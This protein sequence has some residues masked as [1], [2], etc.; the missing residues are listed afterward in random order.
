MLGHGGGV[1]KRLRPV[2]QD[3][4]GRDRFDL[5]TVAVLVDCE[6][7]VMRL[8]RRAAKII[9]GLPAANP[10]PQDEHNYTESLLD[11]C[12]EISGCDRFHCSR[13]GN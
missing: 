3:N 1:R 11:V 6:Q 9:G 8:V 7:G 5:L 10:E 12:R 13:R 4:V 2:V